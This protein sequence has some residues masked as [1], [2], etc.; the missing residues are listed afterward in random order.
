VD[1]AGR[2]WEGDSVR[3]ATKEVR[4]MLILWGQPSFPLETV[5]NYFLA[6][7]ES[8]RNADLEKAI[9]KYQPSDSA[10]WD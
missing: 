10:A 8:R 7:E 9:W 5:G 1:S 4:L 2:I 3:L 6:K